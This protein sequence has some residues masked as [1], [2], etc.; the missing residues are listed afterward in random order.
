MTFHESY[1]E[2]SKAQLAAY[3]KFNVSPSDHDDLIESFGE[4]A[5]DQITYYVKTNAAANGGMFRVFDLW[6]GR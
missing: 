6:L 5:H 1:G 3:K 2:V 4:D